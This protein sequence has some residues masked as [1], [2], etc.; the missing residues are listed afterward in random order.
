MRAE[1]GTLARRVAALE[2]S[3]RPTGARPV[4]KGFSGNA[5]INLFVCMYDTLFHVLS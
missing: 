3:A 4:G 5:V 2:A 1:R